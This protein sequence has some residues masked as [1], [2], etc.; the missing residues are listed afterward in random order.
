M[1]IGEVVG[2]GKLL[3]DYRQSRKL[4]QEKLAAGAGLGART[5]GDLERGSVRQPHPDT[6][7]LLASALHLDAME[8]AAFEAAACGDNSINL[9]EARARALIR[10]LPAELNALI[11][12]EADVCACAAILRRPSKRLLT[13]VGPG[14][15]GK[16]R[17]GIRIAEEM[18]ADF[19]NGVV[20]VG[21]GA[22]CDASLVAS[23]I[24]GQLGLDERGQ[25]PAR[26]VL[27]DYLRD[28]HLLLVLDNYEHILSS[29]PLVADLLAGCPDVKVLA[30]S[31]E[32]LCVQGE[33]ELPVH[34]LELPPLAVCTEWTEIESY[35]SVRLFIER[36][37]AVRHDFELTGDNAHAV[38]QICA[39]LDGLP[40]AIELAAKKVKLLS[41]TAILARLDERLPFLGNGTVDAP[42]RHQTMRGAIDWS[43]DLLDDFQKSLFRQLTVFVGGCTMD[44]AEAICTQVG[45]RPIDT[46]EGLGALVD[47][48]LVHRVEYNGSTRLILLEIIHEYGYALLAVSEERIR[49]ADRHAQYYAE[50]AE[51]AVPYL[52]SA[53]QQVWLERLEREHDNLRAALR[54]FEETDALAQAIQLAGALYKFWLLRGHVAEG[55]TIL[56][57]LLALT[58]EVGNDKFRARAL[59]GAGGLACS[60]D[61]YDHASDYLEQALVAYQTLGDG[62][63]LATVLCNLGSIAMGR[64]DYDRS[65]ELYTRSIAQSRTL[66]APRTLSSA[67]ANIGNVARY[68]GSYEQ[69]RREL[70]ESLAI[71]RALNDASD[72]CLTLGDLGLVSLELGEYQRAADEFEKGLAI[73]EAHDYKRAMIQALAGLGHLAALTGN[74][75]SSVT[76]CDR[77]V[78]IGRLLGTSLLLTETL[79]CLAHVLCLQGSYDRA[80]DTYHAALAVANSISSQVSI[81]SCIEGLGIVVVDKDAARAVRLWGVAATLR[82]QLNIPRAASREA[83]YEAR[84]EV[85][86]QSLG[87]DGFDAPWREGT[88][89]TL[90]EAKLYAAAPTNA[91][92]L[93]GR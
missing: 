88:L 6:V 71:S 62:R 50:L 82:A 89:M 37:R 87:L 49:V 65:W 78:A 68:Q 15:V 22:L 60:V 18:G 83:T 34:P 43:Y 86:R 79:D 41:P 7:Q 38:A 21:L 85:A 84:V 16:T 92:A 74:R 70:E 10:G 81:V 26:D 55:R 32:P 46:L 24:A 48:S 73:A 28:Q 20:F 66:D 77:A 61:E 80:H 5:I 31:R 14:G 53:E 91:Y 59:N 2:F 52:S 29:A 30:T 35:A 39:R 47:K 93:V 33:Q 42:S 76:L 9:F 12:R 51:E 54:W 90:D 63:G 56:D 67:I 45:Q 17:L 64:S 25:R 69:A 27:V 57:R 19:M 13:L 44:A 58:S 40:L 3:R 23:T 72:I 4:T 1:D 8:R 75:D 36:A 11:G